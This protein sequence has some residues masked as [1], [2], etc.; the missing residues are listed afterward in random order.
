V[1]VQFG[2]SLA[3]SQPVPGWVVAQVAD[4]ADR[5]IHS[6]IVVTN[7]DIAQR[8]V[9]P[10]GPSQFRCECAMPL[11]GAE[12]MRQATMT[13]IGRPVAILVD[14]PVVIA[15]VA[16]SSISHSAGTERERIANRINRR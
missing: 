8:S 11:S 4:A 1:A 13:H 5:Y 2:V 6:A 15:P 14:G 16:P 7:D 10:D 3:E 12:R 9:V